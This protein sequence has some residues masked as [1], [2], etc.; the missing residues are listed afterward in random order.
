VLAKILA[1]ASPYS[2]VCS[3]LGDGPNSQK[4]TTC[5]RRVAASKAYRRTVRLIPPL[6]EL[7]GS[8]GGLR[9]SHM[10]TFFM[11]NCVGRRRLTLSLVLLG[12]YGRGV[13]AAVPG[14]SIDTQRVKEVTP[15]EPDDW[16]LTVQVDSAEELREAICTAQ[17]GSVSGPAACNITGQGQETKVELVGHLSLGGEKLP[18]VRGWLKIVGRCGPSLDAS[19]DIHAVGPKCSNCPTP[20][21]GPGISGNTCNDCK[22]AGGDFTET[23]PLTL[24]EGAK[25][26]LHNINIRGCRTRSSGGCIYMSKGDPNVWAAT[27]D[28]GLQGLTYLKAADVAITRGFSQGDAG[29]LFVSQGGL[30]VME[31]CKFENNYSVTSASTGSSETEGSHDVM[32]QSSAALILIDPNPSHVKVSVTSVFNNV[33]NADYIEGFQDT[34]V[35]SAPPT[36]TTPVPTITT[37]TLPEPIPPPPPSATPPTTSPPPVVIV[38]KRELWVDLLIAGAVL[39]LVFLMAVFFFFCCMRSSDSSGSQDGNDGGDDEGEGSSVSDAKKG[40]LV[41]V[42]VSNGGDMEEVEPK[43]IVI[44]SPRQGGSGEVAWESSQEDRVADHLRETHVHPQQMQGPVPYGQLD[45]LSAGRGRTYGKL[46]PLAVSNAGSLGD[47]YGHGR[48]LLHNTI[49]RQGSRTVSSAERGK[50]PKT[51]LS[52]D[53]P[54]S[55]STAL[56]DIA[57]NPLRPPSAVGAPVAVWQPSRV[58]S[59]KRPSTAPVNTRVARADHAPGSWSTAKSTSGWQWKKRQGS[60]HMLRGKGAGVPTQA[61]TTAKGE[62]ARRSEDDGQ[63]KPAWRYLVEKPKRP[64]ELPDPAGPR[65]HYHHSTSGSSDD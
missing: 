36:P 50:A 10:G 43:P 23:R 65:P 21:E 55:A 4:S 3:G 33:A 61:G 53:R 60:A 35:S 27:D 38:E 42:S 18:P 52:P 11:G 48:T 25:V 40:K 28:A 46:E 62:P 51:K 45:P 44:Q 58:A 16:P 41:R 39:L 57:V 14:K 29:G 1:A 2:L 63:P 22:E 47:S 5:E 26:W 37:T 31:R 8:R 6:P 49:D 13:S 12:I 54:S 9:V 30:A 19:C 64:N 15:V 32:V 7:A 24:A 20:L 34:V 56:A 17:G 59:S